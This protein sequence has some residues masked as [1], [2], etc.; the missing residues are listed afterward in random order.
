MFEKYL[1]NVYI[2]DYSD[3]PSKNKINKNKYGQM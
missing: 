1:L 2:L 3:T